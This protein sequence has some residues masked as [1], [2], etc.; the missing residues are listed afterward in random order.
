MR[1]ETPR[2][3][4]ALVLLGMLL[5]SPAGAAVS[6]PPLA[7]RA[8]KPESPYHA[9]ALELVAGLS[10]QG[11][12]APMIAVEE[13]QGSV[14]NVIDA[15]QEPA[16]HLFTAP[17]NVISDA[18][19]G[20]KPYGKN[21]HY[22]DVRALFPMPFQTM[23]WVARKDGDIKSFADLA[24]HP[25]APGPRGSFAE[26]QTATVLKLLGLE[27]RAQ[28]VDIDGGATGPALA[29]NQIAG[30]ATSGSYPIPGLTALA[31]TAPIRL[32]PLTR[33]QAKQERAN[34]GTTVAAI[35]PKGTYPGVDEDTL[36]VALPAGI[37]T[38]RKLSDADAY[39]I[40]KA[41]WTNLATLGQNAPA[42]R[43]VT[44]AM[45]SVLG[46]K[47]HPGALKYY[48]EAHIVVPATLR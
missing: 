27:D 20:N 44:P 7:L 47:L 43:A 12:N 23:H 31:G 5:V 46:A 21:P 10:Q 38:T 28:L 29:G 24:G 26:R 1:L 30:F 39:R 22:G 2:R 18:R 35:I 45:L 6:N 8:G 36:T 13:S 48:R 37:Y 32:L 4:A 15:V 14:Q 34:D 41:F 19:R 16:A 40:T 9:L 11:S 17:P 3:L 25:F 33:E 42:W